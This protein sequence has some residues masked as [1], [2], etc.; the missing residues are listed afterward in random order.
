MTDQ[1]DRAPAVG[2]AVSYLDIVLGSPEFDQEQVLFCAASM[3][4]LSDLFNSKPL[5]RRELTT[6][7]IDNI[8]HIFALLLLV[9]DLQQNRIMLQEE[10]HSN[11][12]LSAPNWPV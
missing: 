4:Q 12:L 7:A 1:P 2:T 10:D 11:F 6:I 9:L 8:I 3:G 5:A